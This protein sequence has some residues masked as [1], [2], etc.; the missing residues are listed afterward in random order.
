M[1]GISCK[2]TTNDVDLS[3]LPNDNSNRQHGIPGAEGPGG[4]GEGEQGSCMGTIESASARNGPCCP[5]HLH[6]MLLVRL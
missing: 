1:H 6:P 4:T 5:M 2:K 3:L